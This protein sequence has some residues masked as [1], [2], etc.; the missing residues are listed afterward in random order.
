MV[1]THPKNEAS[2]DP[3]IKPSNK[4]KVFEIQNEYLTTKTLEQS[5]LCYLIISLAVNSESMPLKPVEKDLTQVLFVELPGVCT[6]MP[7]SSI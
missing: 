4:Q 5:W 7:W 6:W 3:Q 2:I 1:K